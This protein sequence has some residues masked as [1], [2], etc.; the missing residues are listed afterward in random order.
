MTHSGSSNSATLWQDPF[1]SHTGK[2]LFAAPWTEHRSADGDGIRQLSESLKETPG[3][4]DDLG[5]TL[6]HILAVRSGCLEAAQARDHRICR[7]H[8]RRALQE[9]DIALSRLQYVKEG[10][11]AALASWVLGLHTL[12]RAQISMISDPAAARKLAHEALQQLSNITDPL[13][14]GAEADA[15]SAML[16][17]RE[18]ADLEA[19][20]IHL[21]DRVRELADDLEGRISRKEGELNHALV[22]IH[23]NHQRALGLAVGWGLLNLLLITPAVLYGLNW[24]ERTSALLFLLGVPLLWYFTW[25][26]PFQNGLTFF[27][28]IRALRLS[29]IADF[30]ESAGDLPRPH[31]QFWGALEAILEQAE[32]DQE[33]LTGFYLY[34]LPPQF[35]TQWKARA[36]TVGLRERLHGDWLASLTDRHPWPLEQV[37][38]TEPSMIPNITRIWFGVSA[39]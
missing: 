7:Q 30:Q 12:I 27:A 32:R 22:G 23:Q 39:H 25:G 3:G 37:L 2:G 36:I 14:A 18:P 5:T 10:T 31:R 6:G 13:C 20:L 24:A 38:P 29:S 16:L 9:C 34:D 26:R 15:L 11:P 28:H 35:D 33:R 4:P 21:P 1:I 17:V 19:K 8:Y